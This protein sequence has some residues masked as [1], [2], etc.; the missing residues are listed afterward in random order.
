[1]TQQRNRAEGWKHAK[2]SGHKNEALVKS[3]IDNDP[4]Y[5]I[6]DP[7]NLERIDND[8]TNLLNKK[9]PEFINIDTLKD[10]T[11]NIIINKL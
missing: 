4:K 8:F 1:M 9:I 3:L 2:L 6:R 10:G 7:K 11:P 5:N